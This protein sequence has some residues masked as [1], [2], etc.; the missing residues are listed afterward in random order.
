MNLAHVD[1][2]LGLGLETVG[3]VPI[4]VEKAAANPPPHQLGGM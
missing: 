2:G 1:L 4:T 3:L